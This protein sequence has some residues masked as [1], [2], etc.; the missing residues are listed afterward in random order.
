MPTDKYGHT[1][2]KTATLKRHKGCE[3]TLKVLSVKNQ[4]YTTGD[5]NKSPNNIRDSEVN[6]EDEYETIW[7]SNEGKENGNDQNKLQKKMKES[8]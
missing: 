3:Q 4:P 5:K 2:L 8:P 7:N 1:A 6:A